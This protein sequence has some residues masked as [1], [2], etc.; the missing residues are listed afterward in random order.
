[1]VRDWE[2][3]GFFSVGVGRDG[4]ENPPPPPAMSGLVQQGAAR[5]QSALSVSPCR[6]IESSLGSVATKFNFFIHNLAQLRFSG[7]P[8]N[9]EPI[10][11]FSPKVYTLKQDGRVLHAAIFSFQKRYNPDKHYVSLPPARL[12]VPSSVRVLTCGRVPADVRGQA[13]ERSS[14]RA[15][16]HLQDF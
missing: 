12:S 1:M 9:D 11:S 10:L 8:A 6:L 16:V 2:G 15:S 5:P 14:G 13:A 4:S 3:T 7:L